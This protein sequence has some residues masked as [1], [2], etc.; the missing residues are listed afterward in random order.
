MG[1]TRTRS[2]RTWITRGTL[3][4]A[5]LAAAGSA[6]AQGIIVQGPVY[7]HGQVM[8]GPPVY[9][10]DS[11]EYDVHR[12]NC[13]APAWNPNTRYLPGDAVRRNGD[14]YVARRIS[15]RVYNVNSP[16]EWTP[17]YWRELERC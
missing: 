7:R 17:N 11:R 6:M 5:A 15:E 9:A 8:G 13:R 14:V 16:P 4:A 12:H 10:Y 1:E 3:A 2:V